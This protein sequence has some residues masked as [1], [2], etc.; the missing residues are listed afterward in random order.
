MKKSALIVLIITLVVFLVSSVTSVILFV[1]YGF[2][3][4]MTTRTSVVEKI[5]EEEL[6]EIQVN[7]SGSA[8]LKNQT[9][10][11]LE[12]IA[13]KAI[14]KKSETNT[15]SAKLSGTATGTT[16]IVPEIIIESDHE[17]IEISMDNDVSLKSLFG[18]ISMA[19][20]SMVLEVYIPESFKG[21]FSVDDCAGAIEAEFDFNS[22]TING[23]AGK[24][25]AVGA[26]KNVNIEDC[27]GA[28]DVE[29]TGAFDFANIKDCAG[30]VTLIVPKNTKGTITANNCLGGVDSD[31]DISK[32]NGDMFNY[33]GKMNGGG[34]S[35]IVI[36][37]CVGKVNLNSAN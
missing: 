20:N 33:S 16:P 17:T 13:C 28:V 35:R 36:K 7:D 12:D 4:Y 9:K 2:D 3:S 1:N 14:I 22:I 8:E 19:T 23:C 5:E 26:Y 29:I 31:F 11:E 30:K 34:N 27:A 10:I 6:Q 37:D 24:I 18:G 25:D 32:D 15:V 21:E